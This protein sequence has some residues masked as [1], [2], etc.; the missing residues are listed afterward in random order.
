MLIQRAGTGTL[1]P[2]GFT[3]PPWTLL[4]IQWDA[5]PVPDAA[6]PVLGPTT[7]FLGHEDSELDDF[8]SLAQEVNAHVFGWDNE[9]PTRAVAVGAFRAEWRPISN[10]EYL[11]FWDAGGRNTAM[12]ASWLED[13]GEIMV[14][15]Y[16]ACLLAV[17]G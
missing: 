13:G 11:R 16:F 3:L 17:E 5:A 4:A 14:I 1:P 7:V 6:L 10:Q 9:N 2:P 15:I 12:P 8:G